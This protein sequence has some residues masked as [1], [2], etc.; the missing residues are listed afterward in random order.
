[1][2]RADRSAQSGL[3]SAAPTGL[4][5]IFGMEVTQHF[6][7]GL[8]FGDAPAA[9]RP[10]IAFALAKAMAGVG[11]RQRS[12]ARGMSPSDCVGTQKLRFGDPGPMPLGMMAKGEAIT[13]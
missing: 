1:M 9:L 4:R 12:E 6:R 8:T 13:Q 3:F 5:K 7:A 11:Q 2:A 10:A